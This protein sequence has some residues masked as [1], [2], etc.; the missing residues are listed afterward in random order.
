[1]ERALFFLPFGVINSVEYPDKKKN[2]SLENENYVCPRSLFLPY[3]IWIKLWW[4]FCKI[5][6]CNKTWTLVS[7]EVLIKGQTLLQSWNNARVGINSAL[8]VFMPY[9]IIVKKIFDAL[10][11]F[12]FLNFYLRLVMVILVILRFSAL[13]ITVC[14]RQLPIIWEHWLAEKTWKLQKWLTTFHTKKGF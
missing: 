6:M 7:T 10:K 11:F 12:D 2:Y 1:M 8:I 13:Q 5:H 3:F 9:Y 14:H 4:Q